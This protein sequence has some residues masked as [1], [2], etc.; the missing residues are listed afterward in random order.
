LTKELIFH[1]YAFSNYINLIGKDYTDCNKLVEALPYKNVS[2]NKEKDELIY[3]KC[4]H[5]EWKTDFFEF[6]ER[7]LEERVDNFLHL[8]K[9]IDE[10]YEFREEKK[11]LTRRAEILKKYFQLRLKVVDVLKKELRRYR[12]INKENRNKK[13]KTEL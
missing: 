6:A 1:Y 8:L 9:K 7:Q 3:N 2:F 10:Y 5:P 4:V 11:L 13:I 12:K